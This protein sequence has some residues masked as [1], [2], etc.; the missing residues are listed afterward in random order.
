MRISARSLGKIFPACN[1]ASNLVR[2]GGD[3]SNAKITWAKTVSPGL[4]RFTFFRAET[5][6]RRMLR[7]N[8]RSVA[9]PL[10][11]SGMM[12]SE[13]GRGYASLQATV[14]PSSVS[15]HS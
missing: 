15:A 12:R 6:H 11:Q 4:H 2:D 1:K 10:D 5:S 7:G 8:L 9:G 13:V 3:Y 14:S